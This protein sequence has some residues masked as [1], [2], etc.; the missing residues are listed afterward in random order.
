[1]KEE[2]VLDELLYVEEPTPTFGMNP[3]KFM[4]WLFIVSIVMIF[5]SLTS[6]Y[7]VKQ[8]DSAWLSIELPKVL[9]YST[10]VLLLS[11]LSAQMAYRAGKQG[12]RKRSFAFLLITLALGLLF[13]AMQWMGWVDLVRRGIF[14]GGVDYEGNPANPAGSFIYV[15]MGVHA[16]HLIAGLIYWLIVIVMK[17][18]TETQQEN[19]RLHLEMSTIFWHFLDGLWVYLFLFLLLNR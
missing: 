13:L 7:I 5:A 3:K 17:K 4:L 16:F 10:A 14:F 11:S 12:N 19:W 1:M 2:K 15:L 18:K 9:W 6:A 8:A